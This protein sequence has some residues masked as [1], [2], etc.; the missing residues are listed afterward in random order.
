MP[1]IQLVASQGKS[2]YLLAKMIGARRVLE[3]GTSGG[4]STI[5]LARALP[6]DGEVIPLE[7]ERK[8]VQVTRE[9]ITDAV[10]DARVTVV[11][12]FALKRFPR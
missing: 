6:D 2:L 10:L 12:G 8:H 5:W 3:I 7:A 1:E 4:Y 11:V 9:G